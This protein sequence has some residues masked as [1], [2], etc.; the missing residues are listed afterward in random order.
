MSRKAISNACGRKVHKHTYVKLK[1][2]Q[3]KFRNRGRN[4]GRNRLR[5]CEINCATVAVK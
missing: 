2:N 5:S 1:T 3:K 4:R